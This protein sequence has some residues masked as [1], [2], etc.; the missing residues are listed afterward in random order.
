MKHIAYGINAIIKVI[1]GMAFFVLL[2]SVLVCTG[3][4]QIASFYPAQY[5]NYI[6]VLAGCVVLIL[7]CVFL[8]MDRLTVQILKKI[9]IGMLLGLFVLQLFLI[10]LSFEEIG[11]DVDVI[12][13]GAYDFIRI[14][15]SRKFFEVYFANNP[16][17]IPIL[18][19]TVI[20]VQLG[21]FLHFNGYRLML[22][23]GIILVDITIWMLVKVIWKLTQNKLACV[24]G[25]ISA[26]ILI[27][28]SPWIMAPYTDVFSFIF[29]IGT[30]WAYLNMR[31]K[32]INCVCKWTLILSM[33][34]LGFLIKPTNIIIAFAIIILEIFR[35]EEKKAYRDKI[36]GIVCGCAICLGF[37]WGL[38]MGM[39]SYLHYTEDLSAKKPMWHYI[40]MGCNEDSVGKYNE[41][42]DDYTSS[43]LTQEEKT[44]ADQDLIRQRIGTMG[45]TGYAK[46]LVKKTIVDYNTG[47]FD[48]GSWSI[49]EPKSGWTGGGLTNLSQVFW[50]SILVLVWIAGFVTKPM[51]TEKNIALLAVLGMYLYLLLFEAGGRY[52][53]HYVPIYI[54]VGMQ[55]VAWIQ[56]R[57]GEVCKTKTHMQSIS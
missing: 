28:L 34:M 32:V 19:L 25:Y 14:S 49:E 1:Y 39:Q 57:I 15:D 47:L 23:V 51:D 18:F 50:I 7:S 8:K 55:S 35:P 53:Y 17:N 6:C 29:P 10:Y 54:V 2:L 5:A 44:K 36:L 31:E 4:V 42:D 16:N 37:L 27:G 43:F 52:I 40:L 38:R 13:R 21:N 24:L 26:C 12:R 3:L 22:V 46:L 33:A 41:W 45:I 48:W 9:E 20:F 56:E 30:L 11:F